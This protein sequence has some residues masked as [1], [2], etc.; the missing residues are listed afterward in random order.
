MID[1]QRIVKSIKQ[2]PAS[3]ALLSFALFILIDFVVRVSFSHPFDQRLQLTFDTPYRSRAYWAIKD[4]LQQKN[5][6]DVLLLGPSDVAAA[7]TRSEA[8]YLNCR[9]E[10]MTTH[11]S[12]YLEKKLQEIDSPY[13]STSSLAIPGEMPSH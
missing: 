1:L 6:P 7:L 11:R 9:V 5:A 4:F 10:E 12:K 3:A 2:A 8:T 13:K